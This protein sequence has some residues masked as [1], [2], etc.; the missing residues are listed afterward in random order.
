MFR[1]ATGIVGDLRGVITTSVRAVRTRL[2]LMTIELKEEK[3]WLVRS[4]VVGI[5]ALYL[6]TFGLVLA[7]A[8]LVLFASEANRP[9]ILGICAGAF[10][11]AGIGAALYVY[12]AAKKRQPLFD[13]TLAMLKGDEE[14]LN[15]LLKGAPGD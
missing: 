8:A 3:A 13:D 2:E 10:L 11:L 1:Q 15:K 12:L 7:I 14:G 9:A 4:L 5:A 6:V